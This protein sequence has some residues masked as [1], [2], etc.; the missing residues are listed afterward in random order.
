MTWTNR[1]RLFGGLLAVLV[2]V[3]ILTL[4][5]NHRQTQ[6]QSLTATVKTDSYDVGASYG[7]TV[8][9]QNVKENDSVAVGDD[10]FTMQSPQLQQDV[11]NKVK[12][13]S[14]GAYDVNTKKGTITYKATVAGQVDQLSAKLGT[15]MT[16]GQPFARIT[17][18]GSQY[19]VAQ[20]LLTPREYERIQQG[21][22]VEVLLPNNEKI[23][24]SVSNI[25]VSTDRGNAATELRVDS[26]EL[27]DA[28]LSTLTKDGSP[29]VAT[30][31]LRD[32]GP[33]AGVS[34]GVFTFLRQIGLQ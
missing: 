10:L 11:A 29:V 7:G 2:I 22:N 6:A 34:D 5:F 15:T 18:T 19:V 24:G 23:T 16:G 33:L 25:K 4:V 17:V 31:R 27:S 14:T 21:A 1:F 20:Y 13:K 8:I 26:P 28:A 9:K 30:V 12:V 32:D 3:A